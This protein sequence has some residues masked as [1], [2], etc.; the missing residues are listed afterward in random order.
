MDCLVHLNRLE[1][2][3]YIDF[4]IGV[5]KIADTFEVPGI[6]S[7]KNGH[8]QIVAPLLI[9]IYFGCSIIKIMLTRHEKES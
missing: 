1:C 2:N 7:P 9:F 8:L 5:P 6:V 4:Y 3:I